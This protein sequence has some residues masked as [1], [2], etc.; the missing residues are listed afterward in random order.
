MPWE[1]PKKW[2]KDKKQ[3]TNKQSTSV[4]VLATLPGLQFDVRRVVGIQ[5]LET[6]SEDFWIEASYV[7]GDQEKQSFSRNSRSYSDIATS[8]SPR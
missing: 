3:K 8:N 6:T 4:R 1:R 7:L 5:S 2:Q